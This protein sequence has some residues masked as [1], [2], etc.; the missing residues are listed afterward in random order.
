M[1]GLAT[2]HLAQALVDDR[3]HAPGTR[4]EDPVLGTSEY[5]SVARLRQRRLVELSLLLAPERPEQ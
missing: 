1:L 4:A 3:R 5:A 2:A